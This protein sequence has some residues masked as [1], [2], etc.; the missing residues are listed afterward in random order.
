MTQQSKKSQ[1][2][3]KGAPSGLVISLV[4]HAAVFMLAGLLVV[5]NVVN[6]EEKKFVPPKP[7]E[8]PKM[9]LKKPKVKVKKDSKPRSSE[10][11]V[12]K[13]QRADMPEIYLPEMSGIGDGVGTGGGYAGFDLTPDLS[14]VTPFGGG[15]SI[16]ND[17]E[18]T[19]YDMKRRR[20]G[21]LYPYSTEE[22]RHDVKEFMVRGWKPSVWAKYYR[23]P[24][25][26]YTTHFMIP[27]L[28]AN[29]A[30]EAFGQS[31]TAAGLF[32]LHYKGKL[33]Y[34]ED[35]TFRFR[36]HGDELFAVRVDGKI[37]LIACWPGANEDAFASLW[38]SDASDSRRFV[39]G[40]QYAVIG[41]WI[42]L[43]AGEPVDMDVIFGEVNGAISC[44]MLVV[45]VKGEEYPTNPYRLGPK[46][47]MFKTEEPTLTM[48][49]D[50]WYRLD[51]GDASVTNGP[52]FRDYK[53]KPRAAAVTVE[54]E[55]P[56][57]EPVEE[58][59]MRLWTT[60]DD[61]TFE[62]EFMTK[63]A[64]YVVVKT[65]NGKQ[66]KV[67]Y[68]QLSEADQH[69][70]NLATPPDFDINF[71]KKSKQ[72][73]PP[74][75]P[76]WSSAVL[77][78][79]LFE[80]T[81]GLQIKQKGTGDYNYPLTLQ[82]F[83]I[84]E[85]VDGDNYVLLARESTTFTPDDSNNKSH[86][87]YGEPVRV[88]RMATR[89]TAPMRGVKYG[90]FLITMSDSRGKIIQHKTSSNFLFD[91]L[92]ELKRLPVSRHFNRAGER[93]TP[94]RPTVMDRPDWMRNE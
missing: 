33:V 32:M 78:Q 53:S 73:E 93:V 41:D 24:K 1:K 23:A 81:F 85:E 11:I 80:Y 10:R 47:P 92:T 42:T 84:G 22:F 88:D 37:N 27:P 71:T 7:V 40:N 90:G 30:P 39:L 45:E 25:K 87:F 52:V 36:G 29:L 12:T 26:L 65:E 89:D 34:P 61:N 62:A 17:F 63:M 51:P 21:S 9:K 15:M 35:I 77:N 70:V 50:I 57:A 5:F 20:D 68:T 56:A 38:Q 66:H 8:R 58:E 14:D 16:G 69:Y 31:G 91:I 86:E 64:S 60:A 2:I 67:P 3:N 46:L 94:P 82:Y 72:I 48:A 19:F 49:E 59:L 4:V 44:Y 55:P 83:A 18:G 74:D 28:P 43:K 13:V 79:Q 76:P 75:P 6:K 54:P